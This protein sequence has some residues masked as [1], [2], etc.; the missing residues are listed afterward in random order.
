MEQKLKTVSVRLQHNAL[1]GRV[2]PARPQRGEDESGSGVLQVG[3]VGLEGRSL[4]LTVINAGDTAPFTDGARDLSSFNFLLFK[5]QLMTRDT[6]K[7]NDLFQ[8][9]IFMMNC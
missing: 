5:A 1:T 6:P 8:Q 7:A 4:P 9:H 2:A 3:C